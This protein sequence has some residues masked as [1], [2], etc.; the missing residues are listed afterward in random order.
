M[1]SRM[2]TYKSYD[3]ENTLACILQDEL[4]DAHI[5]ERI[6]NTRKNKV[7]VKSNKIRLLL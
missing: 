2:R 5:E 6:W 3:A 1:E 4:D 7:K